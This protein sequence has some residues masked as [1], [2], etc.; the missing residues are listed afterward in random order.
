MAASAATKKPRLAGAAGLVSPPKVCPSFRDIGLDYTIGEE[1]GHGKYGTVKLATRKADGKVFAAKQI[2]TAHLTD[3]GTVA[4]EIAMM[5]TLDHPNILSV[6]DAYE[7]RQDVWIV[8]EQCTGRELFDQIIARGTLTEAD[9]SYVMRQLLLA[10]KEC[11]DH[12]IVHRDLKPE[13]ILLARKPDP[14][15]PLHKAG[16]AIIKVIDFGLS[17]IYR[18]DEH[19][20]LARTVGTPYYVAPE[21]LSHA[22]GKECDLWSVG[23]ILYTLLS[24]CPPFYGDE[25]AGST[26]QNQQI[27]RMVKAGIYTFDFGIWPQ[28]SESAI[29]LIQ[30]LMRIDVA[31]RLTAEEALAHP[32]VI[33]TT[34][35]AAQLEIGEEALQGLLRYTKTTK[36]Q[37]RVYGALAKT[38][39][40]DEMLQLQ[41]EFDRLD[42]NND[43]SITPSD[44]TRA[45]GGKGHVDC[46]GQVAAIV[47]A[48]DLTDD[49]KIS[50][51]EFIVASMQRHL[52]LRE[53]RISSMFHDFLDAHMGGV[54]KA[55]LSAHGFE[56]AVID[57]VFAAADLNHD[58]TIDRSEF[59][60]LLFNGSLY[61][62]SSSLSHSELASM[63]TPTPRT[64][65]AAAAK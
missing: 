19:H 26:E 41:V 50:Y 32:W 21:V 16:D 35:P 44:L 17:C 11:H 53:D 23:V 18:A 29:D 46:A 22:Y 43:G 45:L 10:I 51:K 7:W 24:G 59:E 30:G 25:D 37:K 28:I 62:P 14:A 34:V 49:H 48:V 9:A 2:S 64:P 42:V 47:A 65:S 54:T 55:S 57:E 58:A 36:F 15:Q 61:A 31:T 52:Y 60:I 38:L 40:P 33:G 56:V 63:G 13:N 12:D 4:R 20:L 8:M 6:V 27:L 1:L 39:N 5:R 3:P